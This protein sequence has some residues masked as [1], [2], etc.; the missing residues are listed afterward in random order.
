MKDK[1]LTQRFIVLGIFLFLS[2]TGYTNSPSL[3][4]TPTFPQDKAAQNDDDR[5]SGIETGGLISENETIC[6]PGIPESISNLEEPTGEIDGFLVFQWE[7]KPAG[8][9]WTVIPGA[10]G[11]SYNPEIISVPTMY[12]RGCRELTVQPWTYSNSVLKKVVPKIEGVQLFSTPVTC[13]GGSDGTVKVS[14]AG[15]TPGYLFDWTASDET[16]NELNAASAGLYVVTITDQNGCTFTS[17]SIAVD[18]PEIGIDVSEPFTFDP[19]CA[20]GANGIIYVEAI[21]GI[22]PYSY[23]W[24]NGSNDPAILELVSGTYNVTVTDSL[25]C[26]VTT[27]DIVLHEPEMIQLLNQS[28]PTTCFDSIDGST[29]LAASGGTAPY[30]YLWPDG[31]YSTSRAELAAGTYEIQVIDNNGCQN[32]EEITIVSPDKLEIAPYTVN[33]KTCKASINILPKIGRAHV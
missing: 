9:D 22:P 31:V 17:E 24:S 33:N 5:E 21:D 19:T 27:S 10:I 15:G 26:S 1:A 3:P 23:E 16:G 7:K 28:I 32:T 29:T 20:N 8:G 30:Y 12:R 14:V 25:G 13:K 4:I 6:G 18:E 11:L 2:I